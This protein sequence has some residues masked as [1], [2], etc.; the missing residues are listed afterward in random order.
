MEDF[1]NVLIVPTNESPD[2]IIEDYI[3]IIQY[4]LDRNIPLKEV[5]WMFFDDINRFTTKQFLIDMAKQSLYGLENIHKI[6]T[7]FDEELED[8]EFEY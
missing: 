7:E 4:N 2:E 5:L 6:E 8:D 3:D 1:P